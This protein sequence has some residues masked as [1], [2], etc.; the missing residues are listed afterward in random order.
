M[1]LLRFS[2][3]VSMLSLGAVFL[4]AQNAEDYRIGPRDQINV[5]VRNLEE[6]PDKPYAVDE[7][8][9]VYLPVTGQVQIGGMTA[10]KVSVSCAKS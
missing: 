6:I 9:F 10:R 1:K 2:M 7:G 8:G 5:H 3:A 4:Q